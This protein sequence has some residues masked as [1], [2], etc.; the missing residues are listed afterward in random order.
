MKRAVLLF[1]IILAGC[2]P[3]AA[4]LDIDQ[5]ATQTAAAIAQARPTAA[6]TAS[7]TPSS[8]STLTPT[9]TLTASPTQPP[10][11]PPHIDPIATQT[12]LPGKTGSLPLVYSD[13]DG[14]P[15]TVT[16]ISS[17]TA[18]VQVR[19]ANA[20]TLQIIC[21][22]SGMATVTLVA[23]DGR[24]PGTETR[25]IVEVVQANRPPQITAPADSE[26]Y[27]GETLTLPVSYSDPDG[28]AV[29]IQPSF[30]NGAAA[31]ADMLDLRTVQITCVD[32]GISAVTLE[33]IDGHGGIGSA[34][35]T[36]TVRGNQP[37]GADYIVYSDQAEA[38]L[39]LV[40]QARAEQGLNPL[41]LN[42][43][44]TD[45][46]LA[47]NVDMVTNGFVEH[48]GSDGGSPGDRATTA[49]YNWAIVGENIAAGMSTA[50]E[51]FQ[52]WKDSPGHWENIIRPEFTEMGLSYVYS[53]DA[54]Y[55]H[56]WT[57]TFGRPR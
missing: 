38:V 14:D 24:G 11:Q 15:I 37:P 7:I 52:G 43:V 26:C 12:C 45:A 10:N 18:R 31:R 49:G 32:E 28:D 36:V 42:P 56:Y 41:T 27:A 20:G 16:P 25:F 4:V 33:I 29:Q 53:E 46:A 35:F 19:L 23:N 51:A 40:N 50:A 39:A 3:P 21:I 57:Q 47:H 48:T 1:I 17:D 5:I 54:E 9:S 22:E 44:L 8:T 13:P 55:K 30:S 6:P 34:N 2:S